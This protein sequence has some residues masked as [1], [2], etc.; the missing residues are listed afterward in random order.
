MYTDISLGNN[1]DQQLKIYFSHCSTHSIY[2]ESILNQKN[3]MWL[4][5]LTVKFYGYN[6]ICVILAISI[7][8]Q[9]NNYTQTNEYE[10]HCAPN[11]ESIVLFFQL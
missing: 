6:I 11:F 9:Q 7:Y 10:Y 8:V 4:E 3:I 1:H 5:L 2:L